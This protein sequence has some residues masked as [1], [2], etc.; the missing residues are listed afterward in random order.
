M[1]QSPDVQL[2]EPEP[3]LVK[4]ETTDANV[5]KAETKE[6][7]VVHIIEDNGEFKNILQQSTETNAHNIYLKQTSL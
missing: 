6:E 4:E 7:D 3:V 5:T 1:V 2:V